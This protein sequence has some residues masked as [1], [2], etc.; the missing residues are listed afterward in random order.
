MA[1]AIAMGDLTHAQP[2]HYRVERFSSPSLQLGVRV[3]DRKIYGRNKEAWICLANRTKKSLRGTLHFELPEG[4]KLQIHDASQ[5]PE[6]GWHLSAKGLSFYLAP[7]GWDER[8]VRFIIPNPLDLPDELVIRLSAV[9]AGESA[10]A[11]RAMLRLERAVMEPLPWLTEETALD[12]WPLLHEGDPF[13]FRH[14]GRI[15]GQS[16]PGL[17]GMLNGRLRFLGRQTLASHFGRRDFVRH[18]LHLVQSIPAAVPLRRLLEKL[19]DDRVSPQAADEGAQEL[20]ERFVQR[21]RDRKGR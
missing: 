1:I 3:R 17:V 20:L 6:E 12:L 18:T 15:V 10:A 2:P 11:S 21:T 9:V 8:P 19:L 7:D 16:E 13:C 14:D 5:G 4:W